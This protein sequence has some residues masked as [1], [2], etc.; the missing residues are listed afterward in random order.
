[1]S[2]FLL[3]LAL[4]AAQTGAAA[5]AV[6]QTAQT[7]VLFIGNSLTAAN[8]LAA[9][10][11]ELSRADG[12][13]IETAAVAFGGYSLEDHWKQGPARRTLSAGGWSSVVLQ[14]GPSGQPESEDML[15]EY[16]G[17]FAGEAKKVKAALALYMVW[18]PRS[19]PTTF[20]DVRRSY[21]RTARSLKGLLLPVGDAFA[22]AQ[23]AD[24]RIPILGS[25]GFHPTPLGTYLAA[26][27]IYQ[28]LAGRS[29]TFAPETLESPDNRFPRIQLTGE[30]AAKLTA[31]AAAASRTVTR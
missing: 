17:Y 2:G 8:G 26:I 11:Q 30:T 31:A 13:S 15:L 9:M 21:S 25:D 23:K 3:V 16:A 28:A 18:P 27:V 14:Q 22:A 29:T 10:V 20:A 6:A 12:R 5:P 1:M 19:G 24:A 7:R 4:L